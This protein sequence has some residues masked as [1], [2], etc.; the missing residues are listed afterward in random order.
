MHLL[1]G[2]CCAHTQATQTLCIV[3]ANLP[4]SFGHILDFFESHLIHLRKLG[5]IHA[6]FVLDFLFALC[7]D[8]M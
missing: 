1:K 8:Q 7:L 5:V 4:D 6:R 2:S 3:L